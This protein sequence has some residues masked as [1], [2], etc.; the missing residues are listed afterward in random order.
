[1]SRIIFITG[2]ARSGK[3][4]H[5]LA[6]ASAA[7]GEKVFIATAQAL[8]EEMAERIRKHQAERGPEWRVVDSPIDLASALHETRQ[9]S[10]AVL[11]DC[12][13]LW[14]S[15][16]LCAEKDTTHAFTNFLNE[17]ES[18]RQGDLLLVTNEV[19]L[20]I[21]PENELA[22]KFRDLAGRLNQDVAARAHEAWM[23]VSGIPV[24][25]K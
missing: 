9:T 24:R 25:L 3:S 6:L 20:G 7:K 18:P 11:V 12:L 15:N 14:V 22:R 21:V 17:I 19:G 13:T 16:L 2:G 8:D 4:S 10:G 5:A 23:V 1:M